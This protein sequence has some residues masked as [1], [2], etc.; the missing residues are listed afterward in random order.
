MFSVNHEVS[1]VWKQG[2]ARWQLATHSGLVR[3]SRSVE[4]EKLAPQPV[5]IVGGVFWPDA[6][7]M[8]EWE[9]RDAVTQTIPQHWGVTVG[10][11]PQWIGNTSRNWVAVVPWSRI[12]VALSI[13]ALFFVAP[14][15][16]RWD[17][18]RTWR[19]RGWCANCGYDLRASEGRCPECGTAISAARK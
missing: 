15:I 8:K 3:L 19:R 18:R 11:L 5:G 17:R 7:R 13:P 9:L 2:G 16:W 14:A 10:Y 6:D 4:D 12:V 1:I